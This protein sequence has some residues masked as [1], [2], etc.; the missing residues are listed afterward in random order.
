M[1]LNMRN[2]EYTI[3]MS[4]FG[5]FFFIA[6]FLGLLFMLQMVL[7]IYYKQLSEGH[8]DRQRY[9]IMQNVGMCLH[10]VRQTIRSQIL[11]V[12]FLPLVTAAIHTAFCIPIITRV[13][14]EM[15]LTNNSLIYLI[16]GGTFIAFSLIYALIYTLTAKTY[17]R[18][19]STNSAHA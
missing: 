8:D 15:E 6:L 16:L 2:E 3:Y 11:T 17:Y 19:V 7:M 9:V 1:M 18:I 5:G 12:F 4:I 14:S 10:E 13:L